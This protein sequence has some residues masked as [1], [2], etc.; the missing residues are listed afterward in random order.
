MLVVEVAVTHKTLALLALLVA[1]VVV[2]RVD[3]E[4]PLALL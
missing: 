2:A 4:P 3:M 1:L